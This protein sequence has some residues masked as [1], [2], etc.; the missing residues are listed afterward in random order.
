MIVDNLVLNLFSL[1]KINIDSNTRKKTVVGG[2]RKE[3]FLT[4]LV[5]LKRYKDD[6]AV[7]S[8]T[9]FFSEPEQVQVCHLKLFFTVIFA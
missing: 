5:L 2:G 7:R 8:Y 9:F 3:K 6:I 4:L 1:V